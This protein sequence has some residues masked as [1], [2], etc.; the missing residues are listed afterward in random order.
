MERPDNFDSIF[1]N[2]VMKPQTIIAMKKHEQH[3]VNPW[4]DLYDVNITKEIF[5]I[6]VEEFG[7]NMTVY[8]QGTL[9]RCNPANYTGQILG[10]NIVITENNND[11]KLMIMV[12]TTISN[13]ILKEY[14][15]LGEET[16]TFDEEIDKIA[17]I[18]RD[19]PE[20]PEHIPFSFCL[21]YKF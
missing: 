17:L 9:E 18:E 10:E 15:I 8:V 2:E 3:E 1:F 19:L 21:F 20:I 12:P 16:Q 6:T 5:N 7:L 13:W 14:Q 4:S 11:N